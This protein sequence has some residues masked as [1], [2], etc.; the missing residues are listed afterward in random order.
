M[1]CSN[2]HKSIKKPC[3]GKDQDTTQ[4]IKRLGRRNL[5]FFDQYMSLHFH[6]LIYYY[7]ISKSWRN[8]FRTSLSIYQFWMDPGISKQMSKSEI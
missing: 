6:D 4:M 2:E 5:E 1:N 3:Y 8:C 7:T